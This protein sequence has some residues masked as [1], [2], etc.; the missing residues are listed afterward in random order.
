MTFA[1][2]Y[3]KFYVDCLLAATSVCQSLPLVIFSLQTWLKYKWNQLLSEYRI[4]HGAIGPRYVTSS[5][6]LLNL[7]ILHGSFRLCN[8]LS[9]RRLV[10]WINHL[11]PACWFTFWKSILNTSWAVGLTY[12]IVYLHFFVLWHKQPYMPWYVISFLALSLLLR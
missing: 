2:W 10:S 8:W 9:L 4:Q 6:S 7:D 12:W 5:T 11:P 3:S 1:L